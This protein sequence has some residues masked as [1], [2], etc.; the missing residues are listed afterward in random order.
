M[1]PLIQSTP[2]ITFANPL[3]WGQF[4]ERNYVCVLAV[5][6][7]NDRQPVSKIYFERLMVYERIELSGSFQNRDLVIPGLKIT[8]KIYNR[9]LH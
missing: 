3:I 2:N 1:K 8:E 7:Q 9:I 4:R 5:I 6:R